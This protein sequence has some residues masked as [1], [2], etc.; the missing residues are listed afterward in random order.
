M[1]IWK[2]GRLWSLMCGV[3][4]VDNMDRCIFNNYGFEGFWRMWHR[5]FS[6][7]I[8]RYL[9]IP[10]GG[11]K[12]VRSYIFV[13][14]FVAFWHDH[15]INIILWA[16]I[17][18]LFMIPEIVTKAYFLKRFNHLYD[19]YWFKYISAFVSGLYIYLLCLANLIGFGYGY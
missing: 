1:I 3:D 16:F 12:K 19:K 14:T 9:F 10:L 11:N 2:T 8:K 4:V 13:I 15:T 6:H 5:G 7:W 17:L 18:V